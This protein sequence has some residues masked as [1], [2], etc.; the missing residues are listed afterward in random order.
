MCGGD[1]IED[2]CGNCYDVALAGGGGETVVF[3]YTGGVEGWRV[4]FNGTFNLVV[5]GAQGGNSMNGSSSGQRGSTVTT[6]VYLSEGDSLI[7]LVGGQGQ[8]NG[9][10][11]AGGGGGSFVVKTS[12]IETDYEMLSHQFVVPVAVAGGGA[13]GFN[14]TTPSG[15]GAALDCQGGVAQGSVIGEEG[16]LNGG[17]AGGGFCGNG[18]SA[19]YGQGGISFLEGAFSVPGGGF[20]GGGGQTNTGSN[21][22]GGGGGWCG[23][24]GNTNGQ[25]NSQAGGCFVL[26]E[27]ESMI[28]YEA[29]EGNGVISISF[30][31]PIIPPC[32][33]G[34][35]TIQACNFNPEATNDDG[36][37]DFCFCGP[38]TEYDIELGQ[39]MIVNGSP[40]INGDGCTN[41]N[42][43]LDLLSGYGTCDN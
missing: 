8:S 19:F 18:Q 1:W 11:S 20:G 22:S 39:C 2:E 38:G 34:C 12:T 10:N 6:N 30:S 40:D 35:T 7:L 29:H 31:A 15:I 4:P 21:I 32:E 37:C 41:L 24:N 26:D 43:L 3:Q 14:Q 36:S 25:S 28:N 42:D 9:S 23:G 17:G 27:F 13:G 5:S 33:L 16:L